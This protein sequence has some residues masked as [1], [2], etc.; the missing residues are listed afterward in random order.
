MI[1]PALK[2][3]D[4]QARLLIIAVSLVVFAAVV[5]LSRFTLTVDLGFNVHVFALINAVIN[6]AVSVLLVWALIAV[7]GKNYELHKKLMLGAMV[8][9][10]LF[11]VS[12]ICHHLFAG[13]TKFGGTGTIKGVYYFILLTHIPLAGIILPFILFTAYRGLTGEYAAHKKLAKY[14]WPLWLYVSVTGVLVY[15]LISPYYV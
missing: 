10:I 14:T 15:V 9:S 4:K 7:K 3:N 8:L 12:Y 6:S 13:E 5:F 2:K 1:T 11:L